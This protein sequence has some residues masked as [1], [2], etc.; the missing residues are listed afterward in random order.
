MTDRPRDDTNDTPLFQ[1]MD[2][3]ERTYAPQQVPDAVMPGEEV[4]Q[5]GTA[6]QAGSVGATTDDTSLRATPVVPVRPDP[7]INTPAVAPAGDLRDNDTNSLST[8]DRI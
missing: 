6:G 8:N 5:G 2:Q 3:Q 1:E 4:D 7:T